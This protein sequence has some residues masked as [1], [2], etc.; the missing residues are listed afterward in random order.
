MHCT[1]G[2]RDG[3]RIPSDP[4]ARGLR[5]G[6]FFGLDRTLVPGSS[7]MALAQGLHQRNFYDRYDI[8]RFALR[9]F[10]LRFSRSDATPHVESSTRAALEFV[11]GRG[12]ADMWAL[13][14]E[15]AESL[16]LPTVY[17]DM[18]MLV[19]Q[20]RIDGAA[21]FV[22]TAAPVELAEVVA[23]GLGMTGALGT[24]AEVDDHGRYTGRLTGPILQGAAKASAVEAYAA[25]AGVDLATSSAYSD[26][27]NDLPLLELVGHPEAVNP[28]RRLRVVADQRGWPVREL[29]GGPGSHR[30]RPAGHVIHRLTTLGLESALHAEPHQRSR[31][32]THRFTVEDTG[33]FLRE[34]EETGRFRRD[35]RLGALFHRGK[36]SLRE[37][38]S[39][40]SLHITVEP[41]NRVSAHVDRYSPLAKVQPEDTRPRYSLHRIAAHNITAVAAD[42]ARLIPGR[43]RPRTRAEPPRVMRGGE[44]A[45]YG[46][47]S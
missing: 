26:S 22:T 32:P 19:D 4:P 36:I 37:V 10:S 9:R 40:D 11:A 30:R 17:R 16:I 35:T 18:T 29:R 46:R 44:G 20:H 31:G 34:L 12:Q 27:I 7:L 5:P 42:A 39:C 28:D 24:R 45:G 14:Q 33:A 21:T 15:I 47:P 8:L 2:A 1:P 6:A 3:V 41:G 43:R 38:A 23:Q 13:A 25:A